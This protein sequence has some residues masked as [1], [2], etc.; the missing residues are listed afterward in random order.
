MVNN[1]FFFNFKENVCCRIVKYNKV[2]EFERYGKWVIL[3]FLIE[4]ICRGVRYKIRKLF[5]KY[6]LDEFKLELFVY[7]RNNFF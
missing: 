7:N 6:L 2:F 1:V 3:N 5:F 4:I